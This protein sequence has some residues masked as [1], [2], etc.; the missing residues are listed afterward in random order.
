MGKGRDFPRQTHLEI[1]LKDNF[2]AIKISHISTK[3]SEKF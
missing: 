3:L 2:F 1:Y